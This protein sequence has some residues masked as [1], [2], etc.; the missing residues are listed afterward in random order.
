MNERKDIAKNV[1]IIQKQRVIK[2][3]AVGI[4]ARVCTSHKAQINSL[5]AQVQGLTILAAA[6]RIWFVADIFIDVE[7]A[8]T[9]ITRLE[10]NKM[11]SEFERGGY[12]ILFL[13]KVLVALDVIRKK[14]QKPSE[15]DWQQA[16]VQVLTS[17]YEK[18]FQNTAT[19]SIQTQGH[20]MH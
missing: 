3:Y 16:I 7:S 2:D 10:F 1:T 4:Y 5:A 20:T 19:D 13:L 15:K 14:A 11:I 12:Q 9:G 18:Q 6:H 8:K 17:T